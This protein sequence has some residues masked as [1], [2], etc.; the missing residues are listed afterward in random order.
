MIPFPPV[1]QPSKSARIGQIVWHGLTYH[2]NNHRISLSPCWICPSYSSLVFFQATFTPFAAY[3]L[4]I[5]PSLL[6]LH[7]STSASII[8]VFRPSS[9][10][11][12]RFAPMSLHTQPSNKDGLQTVTASQSQC[13][14]RR[15]SQQLLWPH[16]FESSFVGHSILTL[17]SWYYLFVYFHHRSIPTEPQEKLLV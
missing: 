5:L 7:S 1:S 2:Y 8:I 11:S 14:K 6:A 16:P 3:L 12:T 15:W 9:H 17:L 13:F 10:P 4:P